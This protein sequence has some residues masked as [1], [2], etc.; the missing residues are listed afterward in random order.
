M[1]AVQ[2]SVMTISGPSKFEPGMQESD[3]MDQLPDGKKRND[4]LTRDI[5]LVSLGCFCGPK[6]SFKNIGRGS[7]TLPFDWMRT[8]H[9]GLV[10]FLKNSWDESTNF[11]DFFDFVSKKP[12]PGCNMTTY[13]SFYHSYWHDDPTDP[14]MRIRYKRR[15]VRFNEIDAEV[16]P[17]L[18][19]R[20]IPNT[21]E[22]IDVPELVALLVKR[23]GKQAHLLLIIDFQNTAT[24][25]AIVE[26][27]SNLMVYYLA[28]SAHVD[29]EGLPAPPYG[30]AVNL[31]LDWI[32]GRPVEAM[33]FESIE[34]IIECADPTDWGI[35]GLGGLWAFEDTLEPPPEEPIPGVLPEQR[36]CQLPAVSSAELV[37]HF[38]A[39]APAEGLKC[40]NIS[41]VPLGCTGL[42]KA[43]ILSMGIPSPDLPFDW[44]QISDAGLLHFLR[45]GFEAPIRDGLGAGSQRP[46][47]K[48]GFFD[49]HTRRKVPDSALTACRSHLHSIWHDD[50][51]DPEV[52][53]KFDLQFDLFESLGLGGESVLFVRAVATEAE[54]SRTEELLR[55]LTKKFGKQVALLV[56]CNFQSSTVGP[57]FAEGFDDLMVYYL[58]A[59]AHELPAPYQ[60]PIQC[61]LDW[62]SGKEIQAA[63]SPDVKG[64]LALCDL[65]SW[66]LLGLMGLHAFEGLVSKPVEEG[67]PR[68]PSAEDKWL[69]DVRFEAQ[70]DALVLISLGY[71]E[72]LGRAL[73]SANLNAEGSPFDGTFMRMEGVLH[74]LRNDFADFFDVS[75]PQDVPG[76]SFIVRRSSHHSFWNNKADIDSSRQD[77]EDRIKSLRLLARNDQPKVFVRAA[78][79]AEELS[80]LGELHAELCRRF[81]GQVFLLVLLGGQGQNRTVSVE[82]HYNIIIQFL[83]DDPISTG[84]VHSYVAPVK[85]SLDYVVGKDVKAAVVPDFEALKN[86]AVP[87]TTVPIYGPGGLLIFDDLAAPTS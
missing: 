1:T 87:G 8:R 54:L 84:K 81:S 78:A 6:L 86:L 50:P 17:V 16:K 64:L 47:E 83:A 52:R 41:V 30:V 32:V 2:H 13:R 26:G 29:S 40:E 58:E 9:K 39:K 18:F 25:A 73:E 72:G 10:H 74:F 60:K 5:M 23:H 53:T 80:L 61:A 69:M 68:E 38:S 75:E 37:R 56:I 70:K 77:V 45:K 20:T 21:D 62:I 14:N 65:T 57:H 33:H 11:N 34:K 51:A 82:G 12:V 76:T 28:G 27:V 85:Q 49:F 3:L 67:P 48:R 31:A 35:N 71:H 36:P 24:G 43:S 46:S 59:S 22:L 55:A 63:H 79:T 42:T 19:V 66:G 4:D 15:I 7:E 44:V